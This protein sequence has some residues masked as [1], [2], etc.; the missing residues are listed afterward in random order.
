MK[1][2]SVDRVLELLDM[3]WRHARSGVRPE[4]EKIGFELPEQQINEYLA[5]SLRA[6][7]RPGVSG[8]TVELLP[9]N[10][11]HAVIEIDF[12]TVANW[13]SGLA[14]SLPQP[15]LSG[16]QPVRV[17]LQFEAENGMLTFAVKQAVG[18][19][20]TTIVNSVVVGLIQALGLHQPEQ[21]NASGPIPLPFGLR[22]MWTRK[23][24]LGG[25]T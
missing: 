13:K 9:G 1:T 2:G 17:D 4:A 12:G 6:A 16:R 7:P 3:L 20:G 5:Y 10:E 23:Q 14:G 18:P 15:F 11:I 25:E 19:A 21:Y 22:R 8:A 24:V